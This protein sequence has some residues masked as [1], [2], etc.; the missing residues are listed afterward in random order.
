MDD[1]ERQRAHFEGISDKYYESRHTPNHLVLKELMWSCFFR[2]KAD[3]QGR[4]LRVLEPMCGYCEGRQIV[5]KYLTPQIE[6]FGFDYSKPLVDRVRADDPALRVEHA[7]VTQ[8]ELAAGEPPY[9]LIMLLGGLH[10]VYQHAGVVVERLRRALREGGY[11]VN[12]E[13]THNFTPLSWVR[14]WIY[15]RNAL[16]DDQTE[17]GFWL[18]D[19]DRLFTDA[20]YELVDQVYPGLLTYVLYYNP[21]AFP[22]LNIGG[23]GLVRTLFRLER[24]FF[25]SSLARKLSFATLSIWRKRS[26]IGCAAAGS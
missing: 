2:D 1:I 3:L 23:P 18:S 5:L 15:R 16:F 12:L 14:G 6:Y 10:H 24:P 26:P 25:R 13:P 11:F 17:Q 19:L 9:D 8:F 21:D 22:M 20:G 4:P 7:D